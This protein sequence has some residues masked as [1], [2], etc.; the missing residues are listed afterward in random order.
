MPFL[1]ALTR[2]GDSIL[3]FQPL[4][5]VFN[6]LYVFGQAPGFSWETPVEGTDTLSWTVTDTGHVVING[7]VL[8]QQSVTAVAAGPSY[9]VALTSGTIIDRL[10]DLQYLFPWVGGACDMEFN[11]PLRCYQDSD[12]SWLN[13]QFPQCALS[14]D[15]QETS[16]ESSFTITPSQVKAGQPFTISMRS[17]A[18]DAQLRILDASGRIVFNRKI[19][20]SA[21][22]SLQQAG[23]YLVQMLGNGVPIAP[24]RLIVR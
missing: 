19:N 17:G 12:I 24:Q 6:T 7:V 1:P 21:T 4:A 15:I 2:Q 20:G 9:S 10:G 13:P 18:S 11:Y 5:Q 8:L 16:K 22:F 3:V 14:T 23:M